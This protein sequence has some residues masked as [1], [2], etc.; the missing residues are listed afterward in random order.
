MQADYGECERRIL[1]SEGG[2]TND[3]RDPGGPTNWGITL[4]DARLHWKPNATAEDVRAMPRSVAERIYKEK[5]WDAL[6]G[7]VLPAGVDYAVFDYGVNSGIGRAG[8]VLRAVLGLPTNDWRV[9]ASVLDRLGRVDAQHVADAV[10]QERLTFLQ[11]LPTWHVYGMGWSRRVASV[12]AYSDHLAKD[13][14]GI[15]PPHPET[16]DATGK[17]YGDDAPIDA[18]PVPEP[19]PGFLQPKPTQSATVSSQGTSPVR[20]SDPPA[21]PMAQSD[22]THPQPSLG[23]WRPW[24]AFGLG[25]SGALDGLSQA[26]DYA[27][28][29]SMAKFNLEQLNAAG[30]AHWV[31][32]HPGVLLPVVVLVAAFWLFEEHKKLKALQ[33]ELK[34]K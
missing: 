19:L 11:R 24:A 30:V 12:K 3:P 25:S 22:E 32:Q 14:Q 8:R 15:T 17:A 13:A 2:Y 4:A 29:L 6:S 7:D 33:Q 34:T 18:T 21:T 9:D 16:N 5:Y 20:S 10:C 27:S 28:E 26:N 23:H 1:L 31:I